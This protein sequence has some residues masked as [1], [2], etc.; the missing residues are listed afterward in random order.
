MIFVTW[1]SFATFEDS[2]KPDIEIPHFDKFV[3]FCFYFGMAVL[4]TL[5]VYETVRKGIPLVKTLVVVTVFAIG[6]GILI[7]I[8]QHNFTLQRQGDP[9][10]AIANSCGAIVGSFAM[11]WL[12]SS[13]SRL[14]WE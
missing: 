13:G 7:E 8:L 10:D 5:F 12:F 6:F 3:H 2:D 11:K 4:G 1:A 9:M 14:K